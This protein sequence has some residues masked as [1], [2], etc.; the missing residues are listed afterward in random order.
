MM[1][2]TNNRR[3]PVGIQSFEKIRKGKY[4]YVDKTDLI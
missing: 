3:L 4:L 1:T 2:E